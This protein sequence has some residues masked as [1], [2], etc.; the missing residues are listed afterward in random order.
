MA[1]F[2]DILDQTVN[3]IERPKPYPI[4][5]YLCLVDGPPEFKKIGQNQTDCIDFNL[6]IMQPGETVD[7]AEIEA[8]GGVIGK[9]IRHRLFLT[10]DAKWRLDQ[11]L[12]E[13]LDIPFGTSRKQAIAAAQG[14][15]VYATI[16]HRP[17]QDGTQMFAEIKSTAKV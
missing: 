3:E 8:A 13:H 11:F 17:S 16:G 10:D 9:I 5:T 4:G 1:S 7:P 14:H 12:F 6:K 15:Q 2:Q